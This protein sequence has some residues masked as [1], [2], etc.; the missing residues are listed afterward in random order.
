M[1]VRTRF[2][3]SPTGYLHIGGAR[4]ALFAWLFARHHK[5][6][7]ILRIEDTD[8]ERST[9]PAIQAIIDGLNWL[10]LNF[11][12]G[13]FFQTQHVALYQKAIEVL[14]QEGKAYRCTCSQ[15]RLAELRET[16]TAAKQ[17]PRYDGRCREANI[18][19]DQKHVV[20]FKTPQT[21]TVQ[22]QDEVYGTITVNNDELDDLI[23]TRSDGSPTFNLTNVVDDIDSGITHVIRGEDHINNT[24][25][26]LHIFAALGAQIPIFAHLPMILGE[27]GKRLSKRHGA[28]SV[29]EYQ[30]QGYLPDALINYLVRLG[31]SSG[32]QEIFTRDEMIAKFNLTS[33]S[34][35]PAALNHEKLQWLNQQTM[36]AMPAGDLAAILADTLQQQAITVTQTPDLREVVNTLVERSK[37]LVEMAD[38]ARFIWQAPSEYAEKAAKKFLSAEALP[39]LTALQT[40]LTACQQWEL[41]NLHH[42]VDAVAEQLDLKMGK[43]AQPLRV[44]LTGDTISPPINQTLSLL[45]Q[46]RVLE[47]IARAIEFIDTRT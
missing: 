21:G 15:E 18:S 26:Q 22:Y 27:D 14:L 25:R 9:E 41:D 32:D 39:V 34:K 10:G 1:I 42:I 43:V 44:A 33:I 6:C 23:I 35:S 19:P 46:E 20:R 17:K 45:G 36:K 13:P 12:E 29:L 11:D 7:F 2:A 28:A 30:E 3:P 24:L 16:Q 38:K 40:Q 47:R 4:T 8:R 5:G 31:W 37:T